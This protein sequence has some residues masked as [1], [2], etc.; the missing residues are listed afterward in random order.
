[1]PDQPWHICMSSSE[2]AATRS[3]VHDKARGE[4]RRVRDLQRLTGREPKVHP[5]GICARQ[6]I[7]EATGDCPILF[8]ALDRRAAAAQSDNRDATKRQ[9]ARTP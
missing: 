2:S 5:A 1:V 6:L 9:L 7:C 4:G 8:D 3:D